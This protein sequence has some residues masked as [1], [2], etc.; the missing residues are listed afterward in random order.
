M[1]HTQASSIRWYQTILTVY[2]LCFYH[3]STIICHTS[4][5]ILFA[6][7]RKCFKVIHINPTDI[8]SLQNG[9][10]PSSFTFTLEWNLAHI[11]Q[12]TVNGSPIVR[13][14]CVKDLVHIRIIICDSLWPP[15]LRRAMKYIP[16]D[17]HSPYN[18]TQFTSSLFNITLWTEWYFFP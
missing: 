4:L 16:N 9:L 14:N 3:Q 15:M 17:Y 5:F 1:K 10:N 6:D 12:F 13:P 11:T 2:Y 18:T 7:D 8:I